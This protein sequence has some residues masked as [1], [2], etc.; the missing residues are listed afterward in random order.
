[1]TVDTLGQKGRKPVEFARLPAGFGFSYVPELP[2]IR[3]RTLGAWD[4]T[5]SSAVDALADHVWHWMH[6]DETD[7]ASGAD[8][9][10]V[11]LDWC[12]LL[13]DAQKLR[14]GMDDRPW[15]DPV[16]L[17]SRPD[18]LDLL[19]DHGWFGVPRSADDL[20]VH[21]HR[22]AQKYPDK[23]PG[24]ANWSLGLFWCDSLNA[25]FRHLRLWVAG[26]DVDEETGSSH[27]AAVA[28]HLV[29]VHEFARTGRGVDD[30]PRLPGTDHAGRAG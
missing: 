2:R 14:V 1:M 23:E 8:R 11:A 4:R 27:L 18:V 28:F 22:G 3:P 20:A 29:V 30:R 19:P 5:W 12:L 15:R 24:V 17:E 6:R 9:L 10:L 25:L 26:E 7:P 21:F 16:W 13:M